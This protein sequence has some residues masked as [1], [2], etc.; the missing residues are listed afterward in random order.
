MQF[1]EF[2]TVAGICNV[3][4]TVSCTIRYL[5]NAI[6]Y[7]KNSIYLTGLIPTCLT[8]KVVSRNVSS[9]SPHPRNNFLLLSNKDSEASSNPTKI[10]LI[11]LQKYLYIY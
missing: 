6:I 9:P 7:Y 10:S 3:V 8:P 4:N 2:Y 5:I 1:I 11:Q